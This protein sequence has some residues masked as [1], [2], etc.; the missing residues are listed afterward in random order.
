VE[1]DEAWEF[2]VDQQNDVLWLK[3]RFKRKL[4]VEDVM[5]WLSRS[6]GE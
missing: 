1:S 6:D 2:I 5:A 3:K 4:G